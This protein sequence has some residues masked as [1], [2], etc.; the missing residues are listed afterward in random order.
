MNCLQ[1]V[2]NQISEHSCQDGKKHIAVQTTV[3]T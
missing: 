2:E 1:I 3:R